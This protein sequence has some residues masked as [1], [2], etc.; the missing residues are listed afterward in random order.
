[1]KRVKSLIAYILVISMILTSGIFQVSA[2]NSNATVTFSAG[3]TQKMPNALDEESDIYCLNITVDGRFKSFGFALSYDSTKIQPVELNRTATKYADIDSLSETSPAVEVSAVVKVPDSTDKF[4][5]LVEGK[6]TEYSAQYKFATYGSRQTIHT[7]MFTSEDVSDETKQEYASQKVATFLYRYINGTPAKGDIRLETSKTS[8][9]LNALGYRNDDVKNGLVLLTS[10]NEQLTAHENTLDYS[11][12]YAGSDNVTLG[13]LALSEDE[14]SVAVNGSLG[15]DQTVELTLTAEDTDG[16]SMPVP[17]NVT[18]EFNKGDTSASLSGDTITIPKDSP[19]GTITVKATNKNGIESSEVTINV[20]RAAS[21]PATVLLDGETTKTVAVVGETGVSQTVH[22]T[23]KDQFG[24]DI[25]SGINWSIAKADSGSGA[26]LLSLELKNPEI[27]TTGKITVYNGSPAGDYTVTATKDSATATATLTVTRAGTGVATSFEITGAGGTIELPTK[28]ANT[29]VV[30]LTASAKDAYNQDVTVTWSVSGAEGVS[31][32]HAG[33]LTIPYTARGSI[34]V[35]AT[36]A[37]GTAVTKTITLKKADTLTATEVTLSKTAV[38]VQGANNPDGET[39]AATVYDQYGDEMTAAV[40]V[41]N[42]TYASVGENNVITVDANTPADTTITVTAGSASKTLSVSRQDKSPFSITLDKATDSI[43]IG[44]STT[45]TATVKDQFDSEYSGASITWSVSDSSKGVSVNN[46]TVTVASDAPTQNN[47][48]NVIATVLTS[49]GNKTA[50]VEITVIDRDA[51]TISEPASKSVEYDGNIKSYD[52]SGITVTKKDG[53]TFT[54]TPSITYSRNGNAVSTPTNAGTYDVKLVWSDAD[55]YGEAT[56]KLIIQPKALTIT[57]AAAAEKTYDGTTTVTVTGTLDGKCGSDK[58]EVSLSGVAASANAGTQDVTVTAALSGEAK[59]NYTI[60]APTN[61]TVRI[62]PKLISILSATVNG[63][64]YD[65]TTTAEVNTVSFEGLVSGESLT[66]GTDYTATAAFA[67][68]AAGDSANATVT[69]TLADTPK[70]KNYTLS[71]NTQNTTAKIDKHS[72]NADVASAQNIKVGTTGLLDK[73]PKTEDVQIS[74]LV[75]S[76]SLTGGALKWYTNADCTTEATNDTVKDLAVGATKT[77]YWKY[78]QTNPNYVDTITGQIVLTIVE[79]EPQVVT[80]NNQP[81]NVTYGDTIETALTT[82]VQVNNA[83]VSD[84][85]SISWTSS[86]PSVATVD[87]NGKITVVGAGS[88][89]ITVT[90][91]AVPGKYAAGTAEFTLTVAKKP[92]TVT[93]DDVSR[94]FKEANPTFDF[95]VPDGALVGT[96][97]KDA[98]AVTLTTTATQTS[99]VSIYPITGTSSSAN[100]AVTVTP[101]T[102]EITKADKPAVANVTASYKYDVKGEQAVA[103]TGL[104]ADAGTKSY[105]AGTVTDVN[106]IIADSLSFADD[107]IKFTLNGKSQY[108]A[109][110]ATGSL[111]LTINK[112]DPIGTPTYETFRTTGKTLKDANL[113]IGTITPAEGTLEWIDADGTALAD[114]TA[115]ENR[116][117]YTWRFTPTDSTNYNTLTGEVVLY[118]KK[119]NSNSGSSSSTT[120]N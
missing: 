40:T 39:V 14:E 107:Q 43:K 120:D 71:V 87:A 101:G 58:V 23:V 49:Q 62:N 93:A 22:A 104:P 16:E 88:T 42:T 25:T 37:Q 7:S 28:Q 114:D 91:A 11:F 108:E 6:R 113:S 102:L 47:K 31:I 55:N 17:S 79:G 57:G 8:E 52:F 116:K 92:V 48:V 13:S 54:A 63:K 70:A 59:D 106:D 117:A 105:A 77:L 109:A 73:L 29:K 38:T 115:L 18:Y 34:T 64:M 111:S 96:D 24:D 89:Q 53:S 74:G 100:Y 83:A 35:T 110:S 76:E 3:T 68:A 51:L 97:T 85:G 30:L 10:T 103:I 36:P 80:I 2:V 9:A 118:T 20:T 65:G 45:Y 26:S 12:A 66:M 72:F 82:T 41:N 86:V 46:G 112:A 61:V 69:I 50:T 67:S 90:A 78:T 75:E 27:D 1:M 119:N 19:A 84:H 95:A 44:Q 98:L 99:N 94:K 5:E 32:D 21:V 60:T 15:A 4:G 81:S 56:S 33:N